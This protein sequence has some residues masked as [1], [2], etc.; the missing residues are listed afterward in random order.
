MPRKAKITAVP[1]EQPDAEQGAVGDEAKSDEKIDAE[2]MTDVINEVAVEQPTA[3]VS[4]D[5]GDAEPV[6]ATK[7]KAKR[8]PTKRAPDAATSAV[9]EAKPD[10][11][12]PNEDA[13][14]AC[15]DC[16]KKMSSRTLKYSHGAN[17]VAKRP[18]RETQASDN[19]NVPVQDVTEETIE[20]EIQRRINGRR[21]D[22]SSRREAMVNKLMQDAF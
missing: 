5:T 6:V 8:A 22:R 20:E 1:V 10:V 17:C 3:P 4:Q 13:K 12:S 18:P 9:V 21:N 2:Q 11:E 7:P 15:P 16:G 14:V 19:D